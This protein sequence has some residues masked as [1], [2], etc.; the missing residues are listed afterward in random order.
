M[1]CSRHTNLT[2]TQRKH[3]SKYEN[4]RKWMIEFLR[5]FENHSIK[6]ALVNLIRITKSINLQLFILIL[7]CFG[8]FCDLRR[9][10]VLSPFIEKSM[11]YVMLNI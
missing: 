3:V 2:V 11:C 7:D 1:A 6:I 10:L 9:F 8:V 4:M 5:K